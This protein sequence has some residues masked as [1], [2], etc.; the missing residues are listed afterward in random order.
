MITSKGGSNMNNSTTTSTSKNMSTLNFYPIFSQFEDYSERVWNLF[1]KSFANVTKENGHAFPKRRHAFLAD[2]LENSTA[3]DYVRTAGHMGGSENVLFASVVT[4]QKVCV[5][6]SQ[7]NL[8][9]NEKEKGRRKK[10]NMK[11]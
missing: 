7:K 10:L 11:Q 6:L 5:Y 8:R 3:A 9:R 2:Q 4:K 1:W